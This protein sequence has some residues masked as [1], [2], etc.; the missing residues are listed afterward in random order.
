LAFRKPLS[1]NFGSAE[2]VASMFI[3]GLTHLFK[4]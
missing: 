1:R 4:P 2:I 3:F